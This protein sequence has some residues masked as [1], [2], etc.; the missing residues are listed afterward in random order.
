MQTISETEYCLWEKIEK[1]ECC[2]GG[3]LLSEI[4]A[5]KLFFFNYLFGCIK[6]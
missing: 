1:E 4:I 3:I 6:S 5:I 2:T